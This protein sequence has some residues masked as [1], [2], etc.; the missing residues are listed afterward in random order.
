MINPSMFDP[1]ALEAWYSDEE[2]SLL[3]QT[4]LEKYFQNYFPCFTTEP[5]RKLFRTFVQGLLSPLERKSIEPIALH[6][7]GEKYVRPL[8]QFFSRSPFEEQPLLDIYQEQLSGQIEEGNG[9]LSVDDTGFVKKGNH[10]AGVKRQ[11]C[12]RLG[13]TENFQSGYS[14]PMPEITGTVSWT[15]SF[16]FPGNGFQKS[17]RSY[18]R[19]A[20]FRK[21]KNFPQK[22]RLRSGCSTVP[23]AAACSRPGGSAVMPH[24]GMTMIFGRSRTAGRGMVFCGN[25][26]KKTGIP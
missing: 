6:F 1:I 4:E 10:S 24:M 3:F 21:T 18:I 22:M 26:C 7:S 25:E 13:R 16:I 14:L 20:G 12:G 9:M 15:V 23:C 19:N 11:Y 8:Q 5:Q 17:L 2:S